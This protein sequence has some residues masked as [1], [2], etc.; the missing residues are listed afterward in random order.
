[1]TI[2]ELQEKVAEVKHSSMEEVEK[3]PIADLI[4]TAKKAGVYTK[5][6]IVEKS[7]ICM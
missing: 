6:L 7:W 3:M 4:Y 2:T 5:K 1:M